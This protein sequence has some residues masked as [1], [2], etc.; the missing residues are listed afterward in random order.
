MP[1]KTRTPSRSVYSGYVPRSP[2]AH[3]SG[4][5]PS[6]VARLTSNGWRTRNYKGQ[7]SLFLK[8][9]QASTSRGLL[10]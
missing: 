9:W 4:I 7:A 2:P 8:D 1:E 5:A 3:A 6:T 10:A